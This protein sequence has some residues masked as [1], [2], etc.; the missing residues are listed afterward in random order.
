MQ[1]HYNLV[2]REEERE[3]FPT[4]NV[5]ILTAFYGI[6]RFNL[7]VFF[8]TSALALF[9]GPLLLVVFLRAL[10]EVILSAHRLIG[11]DIDLTS[12]ISKE[13]FCSV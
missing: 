1:N 5:L 2:Y 10:W 7:I 9:H 8:S 6:K 11:M 12:H 13:T 3:I 4:L